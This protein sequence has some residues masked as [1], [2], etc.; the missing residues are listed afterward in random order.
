MELSYLVKKED[1]DFTIGQVLKR[2]FSISNRLF[3]KLLKNHFILRNHCV[4][5]TRDLVKQNDFLVVLLDLEE[6]SLL[7]PTFMPLSIVYEDDFLLILNK[8]AGI[9]IHPSMLHYEDSLS[10]GVQFYFNQIG[11]KKKIRPVNRLDLDTSGLVVFAKC[12]Y[13]QEAL[14][15]QMQNHTFEKEY[16]AL[17]EGFF[18]QKIGSI[19]EPIARKE[20]SIIERC[21]DPEKGQ[22]SVTDYEI[23]KEDFKYHFSLVKCHLKTGRT[24]QIRVH[25]AYLG[26]PLL[27]DTLY[28]NP[29]NFLNRQALHSYRIALVHPVS[30]KQIELL[31]PLPHDFLFLLH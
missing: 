28:G 14:S 22:P 18:D 3:A 7:V 8:P 26:H 27:G 17:C 21:V 24:H 1:E 6:E 13:V 2:E 9:P 15:L 31:A 12:E 29:S 30:K 5:D 20:A 16:L 4:C 19:H 23:L 11:L 10:N 25:M